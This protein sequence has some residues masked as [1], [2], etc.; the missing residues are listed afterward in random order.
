MS[1]PRCTRWCGICRSS[2]PRCAARCASY[3]RRSRGSRA[4]RLRC[5]CGWRSRRRRSARSCRSI[6]RRRK[7]RPSPK[8]LPMIGRC[9]RWLRSPRRRKP[10]RCQSV[11]RCR[12]RARPSRVWCRRRLMILLLSPVA[13]RRRVRVPRLNPLRA[14]M[15]M[16]ATVSRRRS[17]L[18]SAKTCC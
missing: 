9:L 12:W 5:R 18:S 13:N 17:P 14:R 15:L 3:R 11:S 4:F 1:W 7:P 16:S 6:F 2:S 8:R 10:R